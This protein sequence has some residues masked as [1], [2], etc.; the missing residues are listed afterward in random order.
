M[1]N[2]VESVLT[3]AILFV[4]AIHLHYAQIHY[5]RNNIN[6]F[7]FFKHSPDNPFTQATDYLKNKELEGK[8]VQIACGKN[9][10]WYN[11]VGFEYYGFPDTLGWSIDPNNLTK[12]EAEI[13]VGCNQNKMLDWGYIEEKNVDFGDIK[14]YIKNI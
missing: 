8:S 2:Y 12:P 1:K 9:D 10:S 13:V 3:L 7:S 5:S 6:T 4:I 14:I 11:F